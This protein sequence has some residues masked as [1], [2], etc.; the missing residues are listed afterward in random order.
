MSAI[1]ITNAGLDLLRS[2]VG[3]NDN[4]KITYVAVGTSNTAPTV[5]DT[6]LGS[7]AFRKKISS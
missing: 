3:G 1:T 5:N 4:P 6:K 2:G 7:E